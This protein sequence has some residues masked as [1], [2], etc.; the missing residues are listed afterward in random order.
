M[1]EFYLQHKI[2]TDFVYTGKMIFALFDLIKNNYFKKGSKIIA[3][4]T[5]GI[6]GNQSLPSETLVF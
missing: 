4:H 6:Q 1:N 2:T 3:I 5:G